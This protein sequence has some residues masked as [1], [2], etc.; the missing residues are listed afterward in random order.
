MALHKR[1]IKSNFIGYKLVRHNY[2]ANS[3][4]KHQNTKYEQ[5]YK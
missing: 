4:Q 5:I 1:S 3:S 2:N